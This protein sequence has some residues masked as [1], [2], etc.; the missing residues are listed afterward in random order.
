MPGFTLGQNSRGFNA[1]MKTPIFLLGAAVIFW[2]WHSGMLIFAL[3]IATVLEA[4]RWV[5]WRWNLSAK[6][7]KRIANLCLILVMGLIIYLL[8]TDAS[9]YFIYNFLQQ[10]P[11]VFFP[12][13]AAQAYSVKEK[14]DLRT[15]FLL[16]DQTIEADNPS[17]FTVD[18]SYFYLIL[19]LLSA[20]AV[21]LTNFAN[22]AFYGGIFILS[23]IALWS[24]R[25]QRFA[26]G[27]WLSLLLLAG[28]LGFV[29][30]LGL[31]QLHVTVEDRL[32]NWYYNTYERES[33]AFQKTTNLGTVGELKGSNAIDFRVAIDFQKPERFLL[34]ESTYNKYQSSTWLASEA[35]FT[36]VK[37]EENGTSWQLSGQPD[38]DQTITVFSS[39]SGGQGLLKLP[40]G[41]WQINRL[42]VS[43]LEKNQYGTI[44]VTGKDR[45]IA[46]QVQFNPN[47]PNLS[48]D[49]PPTDNDLHIPPAEKAAIA[50]ILPQLNLQG[51]SPAEI[52]PAVDKFFQRNFT[53]SL[54]LTGQNNSM[55][56]VAN[57]LLKNRS[58]HC[59]YFATATTLLLRSLGI[60]TRYAVG[61]SVHE[62]SQLE[63]QYIVRSRHAHAWTLVYLDGKWQTFDTTPA[64][65]TSFEDA[66]ISQWA[67]IGDFWSF[68]MFKFSRWLQWVMGNPTLKYGLPIFGLLIVI[69]IRKF[70]GKKLGLRLAKKARLRDSKPQLVAQV[71][72]FDFIEQA[73]GDLGYIRHQ[74]E[75]L[76]NWIT[77]LE[78]ELP[79]ASGLEDLRRII[80]L[81]YRDRFDPNGINLPER[82]QLKSLIKSW[83]QKYPQAI[84]TQKTLDYQSSSSPKI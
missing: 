42:P 29:G 47:F 21:N 50:Q 46:Y 76:K 19:C 14:V 49:S 20:S 31:Y 27:F 36:P 26:P 5:N 44:K 6:D 54:A 58:G 51:K 62:F 67:I 56:P 11:L 37:A 52:L 10:L 43:Q 2:G 38:S 12:I 64:N 15:L 84:A 68:L 23:A 13:L 72:E 39:L 41:T 1:T 48:E 4:S 82:E 59:E 73:L 24:V 80:E 70:S 9:L 32:V 3:A 30:Y 18:L 61:Y 81:Y 55:T 57:F 45:P 69:V 35:N 25:S 63:N 33:D 28:I 65:W 66:R 77:R 8:A 79:D 7:F 53:Y 83:L 75:S 40:E 22:L 78:N 34:R 16:F 60:P 71:T 74:S 17:K